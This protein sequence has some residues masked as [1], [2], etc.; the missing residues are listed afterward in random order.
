MGGFLARPF[1]RKGEKMGFLDALFGTSSSPEKDDDDEKSTYAKPQN[2][3]EQLASAHYLAENF[4]TGKD[5]IP[6]E[7]PDWA[8]N[9]PNPGDFKPDTEEK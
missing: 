5:P 8:K 6:D 1:L 4:Q 9:L 2:S 3:A 7:P